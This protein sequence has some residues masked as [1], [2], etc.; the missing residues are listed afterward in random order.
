MTSITQHYCIRVTKHSWCEYT[1]LFS[2][3]SYH[4]ELPPKRSQ[5]RLRASI[6][7]ETEGRKLL[8]KESFYL[9]RVDQ[10]AESVS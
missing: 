5:L 8:G 4:K 3:V 9:N 1:W 7:K 10:K 2:G 6:V